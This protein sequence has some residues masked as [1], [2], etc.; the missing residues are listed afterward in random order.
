MITSIINLD[1]DV[2]ADSGDHLDVL[3]DSGDHLKSFLRKPFITKKFKIA[4]NKL[5][6]I[7]STFHK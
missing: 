3:S 6:K 1:L 7:K 5:F 4:V 2:L